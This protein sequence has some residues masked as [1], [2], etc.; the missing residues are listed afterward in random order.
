MGLRE[1]NHSIG[2]MSTQKKKASDLSFESTSC[3]G[4]PTTSLDVLG[5]VRKRESTA[6]QANLRTFG[7]Q[8]G[9]GKIPIAS[10]FP[11]TSLDLFSRN[12]AQICARN[13]EKRTA[14]RPTPLDHSRETMRRDFRSDGG[15]GRES[16][17]ESVTLLLAVG[18]ATR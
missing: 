12:R 7:S 18:R 14:Y 10:A 17:K 9:G 1:V 8:R 6:T 13:P 11:F 15:K 2:S 16:G 3:A 4:L 5:T